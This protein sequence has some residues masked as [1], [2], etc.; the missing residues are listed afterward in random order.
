MAAALAATLRR[1]YALLTDADD[2]EFARLGDMLAW[3]QA[4]PASNLFARQLP[5]AGLDS[6]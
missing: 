2:T 3:L 5:V 4:H 1:Q 6:K